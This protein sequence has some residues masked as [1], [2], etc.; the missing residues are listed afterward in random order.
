MTAE[1]APDITGRDVLPEHAHDLPH[2]ARLKLAEESHAHVQPGKSPLVYVAGPISQDTLEG[3]RA[4]VHAGVD[5]RN[6]GGVPFTPQLS[7]L[8]HLIEPQ[9]YEWYMAL[10]YELIRD[11]VDALVRLPGQSAGADAEVEYAHSLG[12]P[13]FPWEDTEDRR[14]VARWIEQFRNP[15]QST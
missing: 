7:C 5:I 2:E 14:R 9:T 4:G 8:A 6:Y 11:H 12:I 3:I 15:I 10:D 1:T 13:V